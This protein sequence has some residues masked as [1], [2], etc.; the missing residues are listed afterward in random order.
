MATPQPP[1]DDKSRSTCYG[2][3]LKANRFDF[4]RDNA[5]FAAALTYNEKK[6]HSKD[7]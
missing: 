3:D 5:W 1:W 2:G 7:W 4:D 6:T